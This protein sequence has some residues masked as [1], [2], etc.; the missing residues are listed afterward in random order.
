MYI[1]NPILNEK[2]FHA[3][4]IGGNM[5]IT[6]HALINL[7]DLQT[8]KIKFFILPNLT[9]FDAILGND[10]LKNLGAIIHTDENYM[11]IQSNI[12]IP[13]KQH[14][15]DSINSVD[16]RDSHLSVEQK[17]RLNN[18]IKTCPT[19]FSDPDEK[20][21]FTSTVKGEIRITSTDPVY[22]KSY[23]Y[24]MYLKNEV[25]RQVNELLEDGIIEV[26]I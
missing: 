8:E 20:L 15:S 19:L 13:L 21:S 16:I 7:P 17:Q 23:P 3:N 26:S 2:P 12:K 22:S 4:S 6:H 10:T 24:P 14:L 1:R 18:A 25:E 9:S 5:R 11:T